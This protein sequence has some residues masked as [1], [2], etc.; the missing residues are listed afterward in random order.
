MMMDLDD[1][2]PL[3]M[4]D[5][6]AAGGSPND[7]Y[8]LPRPP[9]P[10]AGL[11]RTFTPIDDDYTSAS[12]SYRLPPPT[13]QSTYKGGSSRNGHYPSSSSS[14][15][16]ASAA[17]PTP[18]ATRSGHYHHQ[19]QHHHHHPPSSSSHVPP[20]PA[21]SPFPASMALPPSVVCLGYACIDMCISLSIVILC[22][23]IHRDGK[24]VEEAAAA[25]ENSSVAML[26]AIS[27]TKVLLMSW[28]SHPLHLIKLLTKKEDYPEHPL[29]LPVCPLPLSSSIAVAIVEAKDMGEDIAVVAAWIRQTRRLRGD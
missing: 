16:N 26:M 2:G 9:S 12:A 17:P 19:S 13:P 7:D 21:A 22:T 15:S 1:D 23:H 24:A 28:L 20:H 11:Q 3:K 27:Q 6:E 14:S 4:D 8:V 10:P 29:A 18:A 5:G 25:A